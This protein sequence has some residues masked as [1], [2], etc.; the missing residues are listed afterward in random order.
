METFI[1][2]TVLA[3]LVIGRLY[4]GQLFAEFLSDLPSQERRRI[5]RA[6]SRGLE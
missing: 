3:V 1:V 4:A 2:I 6:L 5:Q